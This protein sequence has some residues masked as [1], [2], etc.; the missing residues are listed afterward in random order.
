MNHI[1]PQELQ[2]SFC[3]LNKEGSRESSLHQK[4]PLGLAGWWG[5]L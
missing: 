5:Q 2:I 1:P 4:S 3:P